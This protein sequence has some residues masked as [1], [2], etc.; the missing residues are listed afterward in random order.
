MKKRSYL[1]LA[2]HLALASFIVTAQNVQA[3]EV[4]AEEGSNALEV[5]APVEENTQVNEETPAVEAAAQ[6]QDQVK[7]TYQAGKTDQGPKVV[8]EEPGQ[9]SE[10]TKTEESQPKNEANKGDAYTVEPHKVSYDGTI[11]RTQHTLDTK[12]WGVQGFETILNNLKSYDGQAA[13]VDAEAATK[14]ADWIRVSFA[15]G[16]EGW[17]DRR[18]LRKGER[19][20]SPVK[21]VNESMTLASGNHTLDSLPWGTAGFKTLKTNL[22]DRQGEVVRV[23][24]LVST[25][26]ANWAYVTFQDS[27]A[28]WV[29]RNALSKKLPGDKYLTEPES[30]KAYGRITG[31]SHT[32]DSK[33]WGIYGY[34]TLVTRQQYPNYRNK[35]VKIDQ[36]VS[37]TRGDWLHIEAVDGSVSGWIDRKGITF[38]GD[39][40]TSPI[41][42]VNYTAHIKNGNHTLDSKPWGAP[43]YETLRSRGQMKAYQGQDVKVTKEVS[44]TR[45]DWVYVNFADGLAGWFDK[46]GIQSGAN[47]A[48][49]QKGDRYT[50]A[51]RQVNYTATIVQGNHTLD[52][53]PW[54]IDGFETLRSRQQMKGHQGEYVKVTKEVSTNRANWAYITL[55]DGTS[56]WFDRAGLVIGKEDAYTSPM[57]DVNYTAYIKNGNHTVDSKPWGI[58]GYQTIKSRQETKAYQ[59]QSVQVDKEVSTNRADWAHVRFNDGTKGWIDAAALTRQAPQTKQKPSTSKGVKVRDVAYAVQHGDTLNSIARDFGISV[60]ALQNYNKH[61][62]P[63][64]LYSGQRIWIP[65]AVAQPMDLARSRDGRKV[66]YLDAGHGGAETGAAAY[67][68]LE[69]NLNLNFTN[70]LATDLRQRGYELILSRTGDQYVSLTG[71]SADANQSNADLFLSIR[72]NASANGAQSGIETFYY[73]YTTGYPSTINGNYHNDAQRL[74]NS[75]YIAGLVQNNLINATG[76]IN[77]GVKRNTFAVVRE[78]M[79]PA[80]LIELGFIDNYNELQKVATPS[81]QQKMVKAIGSAVD[82][83]FKTLY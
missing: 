7:A 62:S 74:T 13:K 40:Y 16:Q 48:P 31:K 68:Y 18:A 3:E 44:T 75:R 71:R 45:A 79:V 15:D 26:R 35:A 66:I 69:K 25:E 28:G 4:P 2:S 83:Y 5:K 41:K 36:A 70:Q 38:S 61:V 67:G 21:E 77:R 19:Y 20:T 27:L 11:V 82:T 6:D 42:E 76:A 46:A 63:S 22:N 53:K 72:H 51:E 34:Q 57:K 10:T 17:T 58:P 49:K 81:Y 32:I 80:V 78:T 8:Y 1:F 52:S 9:A 73:E 60:E 23:S 39:A 59:G 33:P 56:G 12:P 30:L 24:K 55:A 65:E 43:G 64:N 37:T 54:G 29:D 14:R 47:P 50:T